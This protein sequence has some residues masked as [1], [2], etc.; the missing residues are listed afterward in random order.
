MKYYL[1]CLTG[2]DIYSMKH[3]FERNVII[4]R[5]SNITCILQ[6]NLLANNFIVITAVGISF[7]NNI[8]CF[9]VK[10]CLATDNCGSFFVIDI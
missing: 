9:D 10:H 7:I 6:K 8:Q 4:A 5:K 3:G 1:S 2:Y